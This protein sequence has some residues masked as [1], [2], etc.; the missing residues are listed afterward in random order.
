MHVHAH[1]RQLSGEREQ[2]KA[3]LE[4]ES[5][6][7]RGSEKMNHLTQLQQQVQTEV[8]ELQENLSETSKM[9]EEIAYLK[10][11]EIPS[12]KANIARLQCSESE[13]HVH[14]EYSEEF[15]GRASSTC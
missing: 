3:T 9:D 8:R 15:L 14:E 1:R 11:R 12:L 7:A 13:H 4:Q 5:Q 6:R 10:E 2:L